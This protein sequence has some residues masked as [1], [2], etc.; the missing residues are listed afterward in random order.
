ML[1]FIVQRIAFAWCRYVCVHI[2]YRTGLQI[3]MDALQSTS[4]KYNMRIN[5]DSN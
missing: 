4:E 2:T 1:I 3:I 5:K